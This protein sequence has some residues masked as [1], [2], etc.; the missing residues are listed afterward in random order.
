MIPA[1]GKVFCGSNEVWV[2]PHGWNQPGYDAVV[3]KPKQRIVEFFQVT[4][5]ARHDLKLKHFAV[6]LNNMDTNLKYKVLVYMVLPWD[7]INQF[8]L[9]K[10]TGLS[11]MRKLCQGWTVDNNVLTIGL[12]DII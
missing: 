9:G 11:E 8:S 3:V 6:F 12:E 5:A 1:D 2:K 10:V 7:H 4:R